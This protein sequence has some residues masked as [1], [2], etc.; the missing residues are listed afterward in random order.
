MF[1][2]LTLLNYLQERTAH[3]RDE[4]YM[5]YRIKDFHCDS[6]FLFF[7]TTSLPSCGP[8][9]KHES[10]VLGRLSHL[11]FKMQSHLQQMTVLLSG[12]LILC[13][14]MHQP[15]DSDSNTNSQTHTDMHTRNQTSYHY[16]M[17]R[18]FII[19]K[20]QRYA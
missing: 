7:Q 4:V 15:T 18:L 6:V 3:T 10:T 2:S 20:N 12:R 5:F 9:I 13:C 8:L 17:I 11:P 19:I 16:V 14:F 1:T